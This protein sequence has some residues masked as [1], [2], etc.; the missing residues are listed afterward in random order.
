[1]RFDKEKSQMSYDIW[2]GTGRLSIG[3]NAEILVN[4]KMTFPNKEEVEIDFEVHDGFA[5][6]NYQGREYLMLYPTL[7]DVQNNEE[8]ME[9]V[10]DYV[11]FD[12]LDETG[13]RPHDIALTFGKI[14]SS[15][16]LPLNLDTYDSVIRLDAN[17]TPEKALEVINNE[18]RK[19]IKTFYHQDIPEVKNLP[20]RDNGKIEKG[21]LILR[22]DRP[23]EFIAQPKTPAEIAALEN[24]AL[25][26]GTFDKLS[27]IIDMAEMRKMRE[28][29]TDVQFT[30]GEGRIYS[31]TC[32]IDGKQMPVKQLTYRESLRVSQN[33]SRN[34]DP[35][36]TF[37]YPILLQRFAKEI[38]QMEQQNAAEQ[39]EKPATYQDFR[40][41][42]RQ[43]FP[44]G[45]TL[46]LYQ[47]GPDYYQFMNL[48]NLSTDLSDIKPGSMHEH[49]DMPC[50]YGTI[51][52]DDLHPGD[53]EKPMLYTTVHISPEQYGFV[54]P[55]IIHR[56]DE[57]P[58]EMMDHAADNQ[59]K[60]YD[61]EFT[62]MQFQIPQC[63]EFRETMQIENM[64]YRQALKLRYEHQCNDAKSL[65]ECIAL[66]K[67]LRGEDI[68][69]IRPTWLNHDII[70]TLNHNLIGK[71]EPGE[72]SYES[73]LRT[74][75]GLLMREKGLYPHQRYNIAFNCMDTKIPAEDNAVHIAEMLN[76]NFP[77]VSALCE[78]NKVL[79]SINTLIPQHQASVERFIIGQESLASSL[80][81]EPFDDLRDAKRLIYMMSNGQTIDA[82]W[83]RPGS[84][85]Q[86]HYMI[87][88]E[89]GYKVLRQVKEG[90]SLSSPAVVATDDELSGKKVQVHDCYK[91]TGDYLRISDA[92]LYRRQR[93]EGLAP[94]WMV[95]CK[96]DGIQ[97][98]GRPVS[99]ALNHII[100]CATENAKKV[101]DNRTWDLL[102]HYA[103]FSQY[104]DLLQSNGQQQSQGM[105]R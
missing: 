62:H 87:D 58:S 43:K 29:V 97:E 89:N 102:K 41:F 37:T 86:N 28:R 57:T 6:G 5:V 61:G 2:N 85:K 14:V 1:M 10:Q 96:V 12:M 4:D 72:K 21:Y 55:R 16:Q 56:T 8:W 53:I 23:A 39:S 32:K 13:L 66:T 92:S 100:N 54:L 91:M 15:R 40:D 26:N 95:R 45:L 65:A 69:N 17:V 82:Y 30:K 78:G 99:M 90:E 47:L 101:P 70:D 18:V 44:D 88:I 64:P 31:V 71:G 94:E 60:K 3:G 79:V 80:R 33:I 74:E 35:T 34:M 24:E 42:I 83:K 38:R 50:W 49:L 20:E 27:L 11:G 67:V 48:S 98:L 25:M 46:Q 75:A 22:T 51:A 77:K 68:K 59:L 84:G 63:L 104:R 81:I 103:A 9:Q 19:D 52:G 76:R 7:E 36:L 73:A 93:A 105:K